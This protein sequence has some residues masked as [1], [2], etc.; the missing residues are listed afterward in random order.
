[1]LKGLFYRSEGPESAD[2]DVVG[3]SIIQVKDGGFDKFEVYVTS[4]LTSLKEAKLSS[5]IFGV[6]DRTML[7]GRETKTETLQ[8]P[9]EAYSSI[10]TLVLDRCGDDGYFLKST[11]VA[12]PSKQLKR[13]MLKIKKT[14]DLV[15]DSGNIVLL[16]YLIRSKFCG[17]FQTWTVD[18]DGNVLRAVYS[19]SDFQPMTVSAGVCVDVKQVVRAFQGQ[20]ASGDHTIS[21]YT[22]T[23]H[24]VR[25]IWRDCDYFLALNSLSELLNEHGKV[26]PAALD[27]QDDPRLFL[28]YL[29]HKAQKVMAH[30]NYVRF[31]ETLVD[32]LKQYVLRLVHQQPTEIIDFTLQHFQDEGEPKLVSF[33]GSQNADA[34]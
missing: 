11:L 3:S 13:G 22:S 31:N 19:I 7:G 14:G 27:W 32:L 24:L 4:S 26:E 28:D 2:L 12:G 17:T 21:Y 18:I 8:K 9:N 34:E 6:T 1:L 15:F 29:D 25:H 33:V 30:K 23:G 10:K 5:E 20:G 16:R